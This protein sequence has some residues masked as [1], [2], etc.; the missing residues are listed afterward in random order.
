MG[1][2]KI[3]E[4]CGGLEKALDDVADHLAFINHNPIAAQPRYES[5][6]AVWQSVF[7][8]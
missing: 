5:L 4:H 7:V 6:R 1:G 8:Y 3:K 2:S